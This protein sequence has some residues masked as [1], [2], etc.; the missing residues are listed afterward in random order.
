MEK[1]ESKDGLICIFAIENEEVLGFKI[2]YTHPD[3][4]FYSWLGGV[5]EKKRGQGIASQLMKQQHEHIQAL[6][7]NKVRTYGRNER[8]AMLMTNIKHDFD[9]V[10]TFVDDKG[11]HKIIFEKT[12]V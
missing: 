5:H 3:G 8:K 11:R 1:L 7:F 2:G 12:L 9:I 4:V 10:S 6:G